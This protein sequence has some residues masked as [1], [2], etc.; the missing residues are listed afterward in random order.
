MIDYQSMVHFI[1][2]Q[3][4]ANSSEMATVLMTNLELAHSQSSTDGNER[5]VQ[6]INNDMTTEA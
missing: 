4:L 2:K 5:A 6:P 3:G 1:T